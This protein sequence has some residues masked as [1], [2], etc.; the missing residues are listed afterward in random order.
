VNPTCKPA[1]VIFDMDG[2]MLDTERLARVAWNRAMADW[3]QVIPDHVYVQL[4]GRTV[5]DVETILGEEMVLK[6]PFKEVLERK[7]RYL[8]EETAREGIPLK[9]G[10]I[11]LL[12]AVDRLRLAK[13]VA[14][15][16]FRQAVLWKLSLAGLVNRFEVIVCGDDI[17]NGKPAPDI[18]LIAAER[19]QVPA[20]RCI[21]LEDS[22]PGIQAAH[23]AGMIG[24]L[25]PEQGL[26][27]TAMAGIAQGVYP[28]LVEVK[29]FLERLATG[30]PIGG[31]DE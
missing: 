31:A 18:F 30:E 28:S 24:L 20:E 9:P 12:D 11:E 21:V 27:S 17:R 23:R 6:A 14:S 22:E 3:G 1:A 25:V 4:I 2:L 15:S 26:P 5:R 19:L 13:A 16:T 7:T 29:E 10:L 8:E